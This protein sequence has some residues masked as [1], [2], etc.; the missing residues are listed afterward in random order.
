M[1]ILV[2]QGPNLNMLGIREPGIY[3]SVG[4]EDINKRLIE[5]GKQQGVEVSA[6][7]SNYEGG[8]VT[9][10]QEAMGK[11]DGIVLNAGA[12]SH[13]SVAIRDAIS[14]VKLPVIEVHLSN[15]HAREEFRHHSHMS[16]VCLGVVVGFGWRSYL[17]GMMGLIEHLKEKQAAK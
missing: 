15:V 11:M 17:L 16:A 14:A 13:T 10:I 5:Y 1:K 3:G 4:M 12:Y 8:I 6:Y 9:A 7:H 2:I